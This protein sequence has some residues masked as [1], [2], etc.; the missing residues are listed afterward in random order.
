MSRR[1]LGLICEIQSVALRCRSWILHL[2]LPMPRSLAMKQ[3]NR[4]ALPIR[5]DPYILRNRSANSSNASNTSNVTTTTTEEPDAAWLRG[6]LRN[7][8]VVKT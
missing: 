3:T 1:Q 4:V 8:G 2:H 7:H 6:D 5:A